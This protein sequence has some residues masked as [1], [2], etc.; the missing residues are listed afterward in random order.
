MPSPQLAWTPSAMFS[1]FSV[2]TSSISL[3]KFA[4]VAPVISA[5]R[6]LDSASRYDDRLGS[7]T[8]AC[9]DPARFSRLTEIVAG[10]RGSTIWVNRPVMTESAPISA[11]GYIASEFAAYATIRSYCRVSWRFCVVHA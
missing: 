6:M 1:W 3:Y 4:G 9:L 10:A 5:S 11:P 7:A 8:T 2:W